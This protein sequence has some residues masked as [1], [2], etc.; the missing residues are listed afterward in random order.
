MYEWL[1]EQRK[2]VLEAYG[3]VVLVGETGPGTTR[4][5]LLK[6]VS[7]KDRMLDMAFD[8]DVVCVGGGIMVKPHEQWQYKLKELKD[9]FVKTQMLLNSTD[10]WVT[11]SRREPRPGK[12]FESLRNGRAEV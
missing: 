10:A 6:Y 5:G 4:E 8:F 11:V 12:E 9:G 2:E 1:A 3:D 7:P